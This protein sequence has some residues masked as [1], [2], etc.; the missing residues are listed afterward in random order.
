MTRESRAQ[1]RQDV[2]KH[3]EL[4]EQRDS[5]KS[6]LTAVGEWLSGFSI[7]AIAERYGL[8]RD[9]VNRVRKE[10][11]QKAERSDSAKIDVPRET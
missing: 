8:H 6:Q 3:L 10:L 7:A 5:L 1:M 11:R 4:R 9:T 2:A